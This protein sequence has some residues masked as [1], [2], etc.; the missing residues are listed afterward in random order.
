MKTI[1]REHG[2]RYLRAAGCYRKKKLR[3]SEMTVQAVPDE[4][5][6]RFLEIMDVVEYK[7]HS[8]H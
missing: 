8:A 6:P 2:Y 3:L 1:L 5:L 7:R 4:N